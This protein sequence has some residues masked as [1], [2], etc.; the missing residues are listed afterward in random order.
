M[1]QGM[2]QGLAAL[3]RRFDEDTEVVNHL[4][5]SGKTAERIRT[6]HIFQ[7]FF[8]LGEM[9]TVS[10]EITIHRFFFLGYK[11]KKKDL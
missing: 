4:F 8:S 2:V 9:G 6:Q 11:N 5:L 1:K 3:R 7:V 10:I